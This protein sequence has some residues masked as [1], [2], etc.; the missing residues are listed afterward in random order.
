MNR[1]IPTLFF[2]VTPYGP[3]AGTVQALQGVTLPRPEGPFG[4]GTT[5]RQWVDSTRLE[6]FTSDPHD[7]RRLDVYVWYPAALRSARSPTPYVPNIDETERIM[8][9]D[10]AARVRN[11][12]TNSTIEPALSRIPARFPVV[13]FSHGLGSLPMHYTVLAEELASQGYLVASINHSFGSAAT[14]LRRRGAQPLH[15]DWRAAFA[16]SPEA[17]RFWDDQITDWAA[18]IIFV[19]NQLAAENDEVTEFFGRRLDLSRVVTMGHA[20]GGSAA[21]LTGQVDER[22][23]AVVN[24]DGMARNVHARL[25][26]L[27]PV[28]WMQQDRSM[29]DSVSA[30]R[31][32]RA[33]RRLFRNFMR[34][35]DT[36]QDTLMSRAPPGSYV[37]SILRSHDDHFSDL[38]V[39]FA[40]PG[41]VVGF[42]D[43]RRAV[44][45][46]RTYVVRFLAARM[47][48]AD[49]EEL[50]LLGRR[51]PEVRVLTVVNRP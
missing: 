26:M 11:V 30:A 27:V 32:L 22:V 36:N 40:E 42:I 1:Y 10:Y 38:P 3:G 19:V 48:Q 2:L 50:E 4:V 16:I 13:I 12:R 34:R 45:I 8:G 31:N 25:P 15:E 44:D 43:A 39:A 46:V 51:F 47:G 49:V 17:N 29:M 35:L 33:S 28:L 41:R 37:V 23:K 18:D 21:M 5:V 7:P 6:G 9:V 24:L 20:L 14:V